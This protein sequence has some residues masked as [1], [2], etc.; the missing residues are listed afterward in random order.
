MI[1]AYFPNSGELVVKWILELGCEIRTVEHPKEGQVVFHSGLP[2]ETNRPIIYLVRHGFDIVRLH[3]RSSRGW[4]RAYAKADGWSEHVLDWW[5]LA[6]DIIMHDMML[7]DP[8]YVVDVVQQFDPTIELKN[9][10]ALPRQD[11]LSRR[12]MIP[13]GFNRAGLTIQMSHPT[14]FQSISYQAKFFQE[15]HLGLRKAGYI[16]DDE[17]LLHGLLV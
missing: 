11:M 16:E 12:S 2:F 10:N 13:N 14:A 7:E 3:C 1:L 6:D 15:H 5:D 8:T 9:P 4:Q 17:D